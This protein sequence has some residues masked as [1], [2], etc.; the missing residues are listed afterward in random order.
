M[1]DTNHTLQTNTMRYD[2]NVQDSYWKTSPK[3]HM[4][5]IICF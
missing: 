3:S 2:R 5:G 1:S 4:S